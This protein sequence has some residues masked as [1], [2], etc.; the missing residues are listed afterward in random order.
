MPHT[1]QSQEYSRDSGRGDISYK[2]A[3]FNRWNDERNVNVNR[4]D[5]DW[6]DNWWFAGLRYSLHFSLINPLF[7]R[8]FFFSC[9]CQP[10]SMRPISSVF[11]ERARYFLVSSDLLSQRIISRTF[12]VSIFLI[13]NLIYGSF[14]S[15]ERKTAVVTYS[16]VSTKSVSI[17]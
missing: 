5:N 12:R 16:R 9:P 6:N 13:A 2:S 1:I 11:T 7:G 4:N 15:G 17:L 3:I 14:S 8:V 10:P